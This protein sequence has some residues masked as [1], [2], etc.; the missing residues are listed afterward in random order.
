MKRVRSMELTD[1][2]YAEIGKIFM[3]HS[4][5]DSQDQDSRGWNKLYQS[6][7]DLYEGEHE[8]DRD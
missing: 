1:A 6:V 7:I 5:R 2:Q 4:L 8:D 3:A